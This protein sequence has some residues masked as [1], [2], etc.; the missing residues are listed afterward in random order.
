MTSIAITA[1]PDSL[2]EVISRPTTSRRHGHWPTVARLR[3]S[4]STMVTRPDGV[5]GSVAR[6]TLSYTAS[7]SRE[8]SGGRL[9][10]IA[11]VTMTGARPLRIS[12]RRRSG[13]GR[14]NNEGL[15][16]GDFDPAVARLGDVVACLDEQVTLAVR[17]HVHGCGRQAG[18]GEDGTNAHRALEAERDVR[19]LLAGRIGVA[20]DHHLGDGQGP[21]RLQDRRYL[22]GRLVGQGI[23]LE[24]ELEDE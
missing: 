19:F 4:T 23:G 15:P 12:R 13:A 22:R 11:A 24:L 10:M 21:H 6:T 8:N 16:D 14:V 9:T 2:S 20:D 5:R 18:I 17:G 3:S 7:S 1:A